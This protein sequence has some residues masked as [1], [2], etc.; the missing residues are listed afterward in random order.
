MVKTLK[1]ALNLRFPVGCDCVRTP[2][3]DAD[4]DVVLYCVTVP[5]LEFDYLHRLH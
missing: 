1:T 5:T 4:V 2:V 3:P